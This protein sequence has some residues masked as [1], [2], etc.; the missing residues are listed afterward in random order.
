[1]SEA[2]IQNDG[3]TASDSPLAPREWV[4]AEVV[5]EP[6][7]EELPSG[8][9]PSRRKMPAGLPLILFV[10][11]CLSTYFVGFVLYGPLNALFYAVPIMTILACHEAGHYFQAR[12]YHVRS[13]FPF[14]I[15]IPIPPIGT[16]GAVIG[17]SSHIPGRRALFDIGISG[18]LA[19]L[20]PTLLCIVLGLH[21]SELAATM[22]GDPLLQFGEPLL[23]KLLAWAEFG[24]IAQGQTVYLHPLGIAGWVG[25]LITSLNLFPIGQLDGGH[26]LYALL[27]KKAHRVASW[28]LLAAAVA[29]IIFG[30]VWWLLMLFLL[31]MMGPKHPPTR[32]DRQPLGPWRVVIGW[33]TL[34][35]LPLGFTP[36]PLVGDPAPIW[37]W[38]VGMVGPLFS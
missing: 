13:S 10:A 29:V 6:A 33:L 28:L 16:M 11:T 15:P 27:Q 9:S 17:M 34:A 26:V 21:W 24:P 38:L 19:G 25:L 20:V 35:F 18:P 8:R 36:N 7:R 22:P 5:P 1:M 4:L 2:G 30:Y 37:P 14:F 32:D 12:R 23:F 3:G 31:M